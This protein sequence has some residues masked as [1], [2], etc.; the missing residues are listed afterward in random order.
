MYVAQ[1]YLPLVRN[2]YP[3]AEQQSNIGQRDDQYR[4]TILSRRQ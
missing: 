4:F 1:T 3:Y 2:F